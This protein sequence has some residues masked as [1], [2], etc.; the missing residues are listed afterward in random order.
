LLSKSRRRVKGLRV[1]TF[2]RIRPQGLRA[3][4]P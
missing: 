1:T 4:I 2:S 3:K